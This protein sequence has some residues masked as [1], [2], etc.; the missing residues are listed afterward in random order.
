MADRQPKKEIILDIL[1]ILRQYTDEN[2]RLSQKEIADLL[3]KEYGKTV[4]RKAIRRNLMDLIECGYEIE[5][6]ETT[7]ATLN[8]KTGETEEGSVLSDF[9]LVHEF[10]DAELRLLIDSLLSSRH[11]PGTQ[12]GELIGKLA[13]LSSRYFQARTDYIRALASN[14]SE[15]R[16]LFYNIE[17]LDEA[18]SGQR[19]VSFLYGEYGTDRKLRARKDASGEPRR[20]IVNPYRMV[21][22]NGR[23]YLVGNYD[24][25]DNVS[26]YRLDRIL[27]IE[28]LPSAV[29]PMAQVH[30]LE[31]GL[32]LPR[33]MA[34]HI[35]M[36][37]GESAPVTFLARKNLVNDIIDWFGDDAVFFDETEK[38]VSVRVRV[39]LEAMKYWA[40]QYAPH[41]VILSP[42]SLAEE[43]KSGLQG[44]LRNYR[45][46]SLGGSR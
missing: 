6:R 40:M 14:V 11:I 32:D 36:F 24:K 31:H 1:H 4:D 17:I 25:Y 22:A 15:N 42:E 12:R 13:G 16:Q 41:V 8:P 9:Y 28:V 45:K 26:H 39:N 23:Y 18:I 5:Y 2:H 7:R 46:G 34:E 27:D 29:K 37:A 35:Y 19:Q 30:G 10:T 44:A 43:V 38:E 20:Y 3:R 21:V 33:H